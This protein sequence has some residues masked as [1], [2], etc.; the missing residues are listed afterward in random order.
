MNY[1]YAEGK[2]IVSLK[3][4]NSEGNFHAMFYVLQRGF[5]YCSIEVLGNR[6]KIL[7]Y[8]KTPVARKCDPN[9]YRINRRESARGNG[10]SVVVPD[11][12]FFKFL[13]CPRPPSRDFNPPR[14]F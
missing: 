4:P 2:V 5:I 13:E 10:K 11:V 7:K 8:L 14:G 3:P 6:L 1:K 12:W 9:L